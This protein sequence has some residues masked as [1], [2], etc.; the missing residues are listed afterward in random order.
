MLIAETSEN[1]LYSRCMLSLRG[2]LS[3]RSIMSRVA[4]S[5]CC[6]CET[7]EWVSLNFDIF[8]YIFGPNMEEITGGCRRLHDELNISTPQQILLGW[9]NQGG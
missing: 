2:R 5:A 9:L 8:Y 6:S 4:W 1:N 3:E 7:T